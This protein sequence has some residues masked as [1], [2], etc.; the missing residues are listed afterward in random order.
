MRPIDDAKVRFS[1]DGAA[2]YTRDVDR[3]QQSHRAFDASIA[4]MSKN[5]AVFTTGIGLAGAAVAAASA[6]MVQS[7]T[8]AATEIQNLSRLAGA[9]PE[10]FQKL[11]AAAETVGVEQE[12]LA[13]IFKDVNDKF[14]DFVTTGAG[15]LRDFFET[16]APQV[17]VTA[18][19]FARLSGPESLQ[20]YVDSL[21][22]A[23]V[24]QQQM[25][26]FMEALASDATALVP[27][28]SKNGEALQ[29]LGDE[30]ERAG[31]IMSND[32]VQSGAQVDKEMRKI[33]STI[34]DNLN[35]AILENSD[36]ILD[37]AKDMKE[38]WVPAMISVVEFIGKVVSG[39]TDMVTVITKS[40]QAIGLVGQ[41]VQQ[42]PPMS[43]EMQAIQQELF[44]N[45]WLTEEER[46]ARL[47]GSLQ[48]NPESSA[49]IS[50]VPAVL[51][52][53]ILGGTKKKDPPPP[54]LGGGG[55]SPD[56]EDFEALRRRFATQAEILE[57]QQ[58]EALERLREFREMGLAT[59]FEY[60]ETE[61]RIKAEHLDRMAELE[62][63]NQS[64]RLDGMRSVFSDLS[65]LMSSE[66]AKIFKI[67]QQAAIAEAI[68]SGRAAAISAWEKGMKRGGPAVAG[69]YAAASALRTGAMI[70]Q[71]KSA[72]PTGSSS[73]GSVSAG[74]TVASSA[75]IEREE[76]LRVSLDGIDPA[77]LYSGASISTLFDR[78]QDEAGDRGIQFG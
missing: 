47:A 44:A 72:S 45:N 49:T 32:M 52:E 24:S 69:L 39:V 35:K 41:S 76:R 38:V 68:I 16:I 11:A 48:S 2:K 58:A 5:V 3:M 73:G 40:A 67:G 15:P 27:L 77:T 56:R 9:A 8:A 30:A 75:P 74:A 57:E 37:L 59:E 70:S 13:D 62:R 60:N 66:N 43:P 26:F 33:G 17:G 53:T 20:L 19:Q 51:P 31:R 10:Q 63:Q 64:A 12:K 42:L 55:S 29:A 34:R 1:A 50:T 7:A 23:G 21:E 6:R 71:L 25:T 61:A 4:K 46:K 54:S 36:E 78:I 28:F 14:G 65:S 22:R 18:E